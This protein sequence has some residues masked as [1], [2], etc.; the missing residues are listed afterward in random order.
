MALRGVAPITTQAQLTAAR[1][2]VLVPARAAARRLRDEKWEAYYERRRAASDAIAASAAIAAIAAKFKARIADMDSAFAKAAPLDSDVVVYRGVSKKLP[3]D[4]IDK[5]FTSTSWERGKADEFSGDKGEILAIRIPAGSKVIKM[6]DDEGESEILLPRNGQFTKGADG[7]YTY[8]E[9]R[10]TAVGTVKAV[11]KPND[12]NRL[13]TRDAKGWET[14][15]DPV[16]ITKAASGPVQRSTPATVTVG[17]PKKDGIYTEYKVKV[18][19]ETLTAYEDGKGVI[20]IDGVPT[21][22]KSMAE[23]TSWLTKY[24]IPD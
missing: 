3:D 7:T 6:S 15:G 18:A 23:A 5:G 21:T 10:P 16:Q 1:N 19:G 17:K 24:Q 11:G 2:G 8:T 22:F 9:G 4:F 20:D 14:D 13:Y 12:T